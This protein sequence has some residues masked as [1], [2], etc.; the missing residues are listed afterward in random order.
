MRW[1]IRNQILIPLLAIQA[2][3]VT[4]ATV[5]M[6]TLAVRRS[7][8]EI[9]GRLNDVVDTLSHGNF[10]YTESVLNRMRGL[11]GAHFIVGDAGG[12]VLHTTLP[13]VEGLPAAL[14]NL[15]NAGH[16]GS[17]RDSPAVLLERTPYFAMSVQTQNG[18]PGDS[19]FILYPR[20]SLQQARW[21]AVMPSVSL[22]TASLGVMMVVT[23]WI[24]NH[25]SGRIRRVQRQ[26]ARIADGDFHEVDPGGRG[27]EVADLT[28]SINRMSAQLN[29]MQQTIHQS[30]RARLLAQLGA[31]LAHQLRNSLTGARLSVQLHVKRHPA[32]ADDQTLTVALRQLAL[33]EEQVR[34]L[35]SIGRLERRP[36]EVCELRQVLA[37]VAF[38]VG[39]ACQ[40]AKVNFTQPAEDAP[41][42]IEI[43]AD[44]SG[45]RA[46]ILN[47][48]LNAI[49]AA[50]QGG[51]VAVE[52]H[53]QQDEVTIE[54]V[55]NGP[56]P[57]PELAETLCD[58]FVTSKP[59]GV[60]LGLALA[61]QVAADHGG[62]LSW[63][64]SGGETRFCL[65]LP[66]R[67]GLPA[68]EAQWVAS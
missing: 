55:D 43:L 13:R 58:A 18:P 21:E 48:A 63:S 61:R 47:L 3:A 56:G 64:R 27:D 59:E 19:L 20:T 41:E 5:T 9:I 29:G 35:L 60:G 11:S 10:P 57:A 26:V 68:E 42:S 17:L 24:A 40:H 53:R 32:A 65:A 49:E 52:I 30:E 16:I 1:S 14:R 51:S 4:A 25:I 46:A 12:K 28:R 22:G 34:G 33:T 39:P 6:A 50:G 8:R 62:R 44:R 37:D 67:S 7:E 23:S 66:N 38:L 15:P 54:I 2:V 36:A 45:I 31:G